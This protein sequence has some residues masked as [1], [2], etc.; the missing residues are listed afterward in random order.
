M[1]DELP[2]YSL[3]LYLQHVASL[4]LRQ[5]DQILSEQLGIG[6]SQFRVLELLAAKPN[7][8]Q[9]QVGQALGQTE[10]SISR[11]VKLLQAKQMVQVVR[12]PLNQR[13]HDVSLTVKGERLCLAAGEALSRYHQPVF[14]SLSDKQQLELRKLLSI[15]DDNLSDFSNNQ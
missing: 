1:K 14:K 3:E 5:S 15:L 11:Q 13:Q 2:E 8:P 10:A 9:R 12:N 4:L 6:M 7:I